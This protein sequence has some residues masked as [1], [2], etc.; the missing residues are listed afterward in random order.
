MGEDRGHLRQIVD[1]VTDQLFS[2]VIPVAVLSYAAP[3]KSVDFIMQTAQSKYDQ[4]QSINFEAIGTGISD[5]FNKTVPMLQ[6]E[7]DVMK[8]V[9]D[10]TPQYVEQAYAYAELIPWEWWAGFGAVIVLIGLCIPWRRISEW[11]SASVWRTVLLLTTVLP[12]DEGLDVLEDKEAGNYAIMVTISSILCTL[13][14]NYAI[15]WVTWWIVRTILRKIRNLIWGT[16][17][18]IFGGI[19][20]SIFR[21]NK[22]SASDDTKSKVEADDEKVK[23]VDVP[24]QVLTDDQA[25]PSIDSQ[26]TSVEDPTK[27][28][29]A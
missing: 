12:L 29:D 10:E 6:T 8:V 1:M 18:G 11:L 5:V 16:I 14:I 3:Q 23:E 25:I 21:R 19:F 24:E 20:G 7:V 13:A 26:V 4:I 15:L 2:M 22:K 9:A 17:K 27:P 28:K